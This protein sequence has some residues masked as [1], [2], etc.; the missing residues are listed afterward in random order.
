MGTQRDSEGQPCVAGNYVPCWVPGPCAYSV[1]GRWVDSLWKDRKLTDEKYEEYLFACRDGVLARKRNLDAV[2]ERQAAL[3]E[4][5][6]VQAQVRSVRGSSTW[7]PYPQVPEALA[8]LSLFWE[9]RDR[10]P[11]LL[12]IGPSHTGKTEWA[13][14]LFSCYLEVKIGGLTYF[15]E[16]MR[17]F[18]RKKHTGI[19]LEDVRDLQ[20]LVEH[21]EKLQGKCDGLIEFASTPGGTR[22]YQRNMWRIPV[23]VTT[24]YT[25][26]N[27]GLVHS[28]DFL[29]N[30]ANR[31]LVYFD[32]P[33][34]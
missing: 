7:R 32:G 2:K 24:N 33:V 1:A 31:E 27:L 12:V 14:S 19:V 9:A 29:G 4:E 5:E 30:P 16:S 26:R 28:D 18:N 21:Q 17:K 8:W 34:C 20:F 25:T 6:E 10:Y 15:P 11:F 23:V 13:K 22:S 3:E